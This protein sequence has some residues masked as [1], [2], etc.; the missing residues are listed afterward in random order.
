MP[1][2]FNVCSKKKI[3]NYIDFGEVVHYSNQTIQII[4][5]CQFRFQNQLMNKINI[6]E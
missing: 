6:V 5:F 1:K 2:Q 3:N 4:I